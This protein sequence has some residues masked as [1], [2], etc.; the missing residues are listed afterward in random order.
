MEVMSAFG[1]GVFGSVLA[2]TVAI[3][4]LYRASRVGRL[5]ERYHR[6]GF[7]TA[8]AL[9]AVLAGGLAVAFDVDHPVK[10]I[11]IGAAA[12]IV[13]RKMAGGDNLETSA[14]TSNPRTG[15]V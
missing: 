4:E 5:P 6:I 2:E 12:L 10:A 7:W 15:W 1:W 9:L 13:A 3:I 8:R 11:C 14:R